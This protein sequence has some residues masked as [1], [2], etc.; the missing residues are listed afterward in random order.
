MIEKIRHWEFVD[1]ALLLESADQG[2]SPGRM[3]FTFDPSCQDSKEGS[4]SHQGPH[5][6]APSLLPLHGGS[7]IS[8]SH[9]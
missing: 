4:L 5:H 2:Y 1:L 8:S 3:Y 7:F 9:L 6:L